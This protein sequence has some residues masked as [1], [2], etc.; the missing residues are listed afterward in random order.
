MAVSHKFRG[1]GRVNGLVNSHVRAHVIGNLAGRPCRIPLLL[2]GRLEA[3]LVHADSLFLQNFHGKVK[4]KSVSVIQTESVLAG[5]HVFALLFDCLLHI[6][7]NTKTLVDGLVEFI[8]LLGKDIEN[9]ILL[10]LQ[11]GIAVLTA[12]NHGIA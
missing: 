2:H 8:F 7:Q 9:K 12:L 11:L 4:R 6:V 3:L 10:F 5:K 1:N